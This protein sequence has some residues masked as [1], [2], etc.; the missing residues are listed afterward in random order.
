[1]AALSCA[2]SRTCTRSPGTSPPWTSSCCS[3]KSGNHNEAQATSNV[4]L[5]LHRES[6][7]AVKFL[8]FSHTVPFAAFSG[9]VIALSFLVKLLIVFCDGF[10]SHYG[11][12]R[13][14]FGQRIG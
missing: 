7:P 11:N 1:M 14:E 3:F 13:G 4:I 12:T 2:S 10:L 9:S 6:D 5:K 8:P